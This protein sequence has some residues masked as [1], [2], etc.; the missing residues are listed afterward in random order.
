MA[1]KFRVIDNMFV[2]DGILLVALIRSM[3]MPTGLTSYILGATNVSI[4]DFLIGGI[5]IFVYIIMI[6]LVGC[7]LWY[8]SGTDVAENEDT[9]ALDINSTPLG[10]AVI[11]IM[12]VV[13]LAIIIFVS[14]WAKN[15]FD[16]KFDEA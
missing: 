7:A 13:S 14:I 11:V 9:L 1:E 12:L 8:S 4:G 3:A 15:M 5:F 2:T 10:I 16:A 6:V